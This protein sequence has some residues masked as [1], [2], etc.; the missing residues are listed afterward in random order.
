MADRIF[1]YFGEGTAFAAVRKQTD[2]PKNGPWTNHN[3]K[4]F[5]A[6]HEEEEKPASD[7]G[8]KDPDGLVKCIGIVGRYHGNEALLDKVEE[9][10][11]V[12]QVWEGGEGGI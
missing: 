7:S 8:S 2:S 11:R 6:K 1:K 9:C 10:V 5:L 3:I 4:I 12:T